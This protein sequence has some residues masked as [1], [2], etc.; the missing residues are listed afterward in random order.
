MCVGVLKENKMGQEYTALVLSVCSLNHRA[1]R[2]MTHTTELPA[3]LEVRAQ[4]CVFT[5]A[6]P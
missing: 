4:G 6:S 5:E 1:R 3:S 2:S